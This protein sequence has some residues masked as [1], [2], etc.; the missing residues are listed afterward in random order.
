MP[1]RRVG[2]SNKILSSELKMTSAMTDVNEAAAT[3]SKFGKHE[4]LIKYLMIGGM[5]SAVDVGLFLILFN[6]I[7]T[8]EMVAQFI[9]VP[10]SVLFSF[11]V[12]AR[13]N[14]K[15]NDYMWLR[16][17]SFIVVCTVGM[18]LGLFIIK[19][20]ADLGIGASLTDPENVGKF[21]SLPFVFVFQFLL[22]SKITF[23]KAH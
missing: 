19:F 20:I 16:L 10:T 13:H 17:F 21:V 2:K 9:A 6:V 18:Y 1:P 22:N 14:F 5:A 12:N 8:T 11:I 15:S 23:R 3:P 4:H 7:G